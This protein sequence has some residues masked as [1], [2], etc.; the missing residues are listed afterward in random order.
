MR[1][2]PVTQIS[3]FLAN[4][5]GVVAHLCAALAQRDVN[6]LAMTVL[7]TVDIGTMRMVVDNVSAA[8][9]ALNGSG[10]AYVEVPVISIA[11][12]NKKGAFARISRVLANAEVNIEY[13]YATAAPGTDHTLGIF[14]VSNR[15]A[16][17]ELDFDGEA[18]R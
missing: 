6:I 12:P 2:T 7:D 9:D 5:P 18:D 10:A 16:A 13:F 17:L 1:C 11:I 4:K 15:E 3:V 8:Q 14:R